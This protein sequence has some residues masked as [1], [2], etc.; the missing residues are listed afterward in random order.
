MG[1]LGRGEGSGGQRRFLAPDTPHFADPCVGIQPGQGEQ[2]VAG[3]FDPVFRS[4]LP[5]YKGRCMKAPRQGGGGD[6]RASAA[7]LWFAFWRGRL[8]LTLRG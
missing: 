3:P 4:H 7:H 1:I 8:H 6:S 5:R 2:L